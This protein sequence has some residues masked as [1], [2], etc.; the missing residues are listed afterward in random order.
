[1]ADQEAKRKAEEDKQERR[2]QAWLHQQQKLEEMR[3][4]DE[5]RKYIRDKQKE[6]FQKEAREKKEADQARIKLSMDN[7]AHKMDDKYTEFK[8]KQD[9]EH[10]REERLNNLRLLQQEEGAR[11]VWAS[12]NGMSRH[13]IIIA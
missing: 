13:D 11:V 10:A 5:R 8:R 12:F 1:M 7:L 6:Q 4:N 3:A 9:L 2:R